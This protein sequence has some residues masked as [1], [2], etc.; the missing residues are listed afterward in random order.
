MNTMIGKL[1]KIASVAMVVAIMTGPTIVLAA[2]PTKPKPIV[3]GVVDVLDFDTEWTQNTPNGPVYPEE[4]QTAPH[5]AGPNEIAV[6]TMSAF[7]APSGGYY[8]FL[9]FR[10]AVSKDGWPFEPIL[11]STK[12]VDG[13]SDG[14]A[15]VSITKKMALTEGV[16]YEFGAEF[17][18][19]APVVVG[20]AT[21][22]GTVT[23]LRLGS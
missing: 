17:H 18:T 20:W 16:T 5:Q 4:C 2:P 19:A 21:C 15:Q 9:Y 22:Q 23:F 3:S 6:I 14:A 7:L 1:G 8:D 11:P 13:M 10:V 12:T